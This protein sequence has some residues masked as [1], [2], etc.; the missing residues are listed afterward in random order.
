MKKI[1]TILCFAAITF[2][3]CHNDGSST[4]GV[5][6][7]DEKAATEHKETKENL[8]K[9]NEDKTEAPGEMKATTDSSKSKR[10]DSMNAKPGM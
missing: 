2:T 10:S 4:I 3:A 7:N 6:E 5:Y 8:D 1:T 9:S